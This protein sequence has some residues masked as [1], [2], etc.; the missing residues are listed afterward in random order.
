MVDA[1]DCIYEAD[2]EAFIDYY[3][4]L[5]KICKVHLQY[6]HDVLFPAEVE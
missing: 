4:R 5:N 1:N 6:P 2:L 3:P